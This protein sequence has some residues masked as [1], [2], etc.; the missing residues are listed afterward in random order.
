MIWY[1]SCSSSV[2]VSKRPPTFQFTGIPYRLV[3]P[4]DRDCSYTEA[5]KSGSELEKYF[6]FMHFAFKAFLL[7]KVSSWKSILLLERQESVDKLPLFLNS[8]RMIIN[9]NCFPCVSNGG[10]DFLSSRG[11]D[12]SCQ[13]V[14][15]GESLDLC[16]SPEK[17]FLTVYIIKNQTLLILQRFSPCLEVAYNNGNKSGIAVPLRDPK[18]CLWHSLLQTPFQI[19]IM[20]M[21]CVKFTIKC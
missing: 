2:W 16:G 17:N 19:N 20:N 15:K 11:C 7:Q 21:N 13:E 12:R 6:I 3:V 14:W 1:H 10:L 4:I 8:H 5:R 9:G 18:H